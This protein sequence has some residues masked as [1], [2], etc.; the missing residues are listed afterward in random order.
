MGTSKGIGGPH[1]GR[2]SDADRL[3]RRYQTE[4][5]RASPPGNA[6]PRGQEVTDEYHEALVET[7]R[8]DSGAFGLRAAMYTGGIRLIDALEALN[9]DSIE[10]WGQLD[11]DNAQ[12][13]RDD[14]A[15]RFVDAIAGRGDTIANAAIRRAVAGRCVNHLLS[16][17]AVA[18]SIS[19]GQPGGGTLISEDLFC[20]IY[21]LFFADA[22]GEFIKTAIAEKI[23]LAVP[24]LYVLDPAGKVSDWIAE[25]I[26]AVLPKPCEAKESK[27]SEGPSIGELARGMLE[28]TV[29]RALGLD[30]VGQAVG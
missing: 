12:E 6:E 1:G 18:S 24:A 27:G 23:K 17:N 19:N 20:A 14:F 11:G 8:K 22:I 25:R 26:Y 30:P 15:M 7:L 3:L 5:A 28:E 10:C 9:R 21:G 2:W 16:R 13:R 29:D 4:L